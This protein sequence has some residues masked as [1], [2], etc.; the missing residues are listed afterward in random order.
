MK[1]ILP[2]AFLFLIANSL[3]TAASAQVVAAGHDHTLYVCSNGT[4]NAW[5]ANSSGQLGDSTQEDR[6][7]SIHVH[8]LTDVVAV[9]AGD[10]HSPFLKSDGTVWACGS[11]QYGQLGD[12]TFINRSVP[13]RVHWLTGV[14][15]IGA[16][17]GIHSP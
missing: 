16:G 9:A 11:N 5:G 10:Y 1:S 12:S 8:G 2:A 14:I 7:N 3:H 15:S 17:F 6:H 13:V 4:V